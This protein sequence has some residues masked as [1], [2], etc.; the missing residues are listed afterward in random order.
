VKQDVLLTV[1]VAAAIELPRRFPGSATT[2]ARG[3]V[4][5][6]SPA[7]SRYR[8][9]QRRRAWSTCRARQARVN[10]ARAA[11]A[12][13]QRRLGCRPRARRNTLRLFGAR[14]AEGRFQEV[15]APYPAARD[16]GRW[17]PMSGQVY[18][19]PPLFPE[20]WLRGENRTS[21]KAVEGCAQRRMNA[22]PVPYPMSIAVSAEACDLSRQT[23]LSSWNALSARSARNKSPGVGAGSY[24]PQHRVP[25]PRAAS[26]K[27]PPL[28]GR[29]VPRE[30]RGQVWEGCLPLTGGRCVGGLLEHGRNGLTTYG[31]LVMIYVNRQVP[32][33]LS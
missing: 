21:W 11:V 7:G 29:G 33:G 32:G 10:Q 19:R 17:P 4:P 26:K 2:S 6:P 9:S 27:T 24:A 14:T 12:L 1:V 3:N 25:R 20:R 28:R 13:T 16:Y 31:F 18:S 23:H 5:G 8:Q 15:S 22:G 30:R